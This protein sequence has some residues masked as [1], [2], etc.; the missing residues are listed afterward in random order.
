MKKIWVPTWEK[1]LKYL[2]RL[3]AAY[4]ITHD[5]REEIGDMLRYADSHDETTNAMD[6]RA[7]QISKRIKNENVYNGTDGDNWSRQDPYGR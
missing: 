1:H 7:E 4:H 6:R 2:H 5:E 3:R